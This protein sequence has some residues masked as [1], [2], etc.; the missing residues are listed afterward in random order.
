M[1][2]NLNELARMVENCNN[3]DDFVLFYKC[4]QIADYLSYVM[5][6]KVSN[7]YAIEIPQLL[8]KYSGVSNDIVSARMGLFFELWDKNIWNELE[9]TRNEKFKELEGGWLSVVV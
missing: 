6:C 1:P 9:N 7:D 4:S 3:G 8:L 2:V 5:E